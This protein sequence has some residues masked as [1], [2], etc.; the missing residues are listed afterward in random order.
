MIELLGSGQLNRRQAKIAYNSNYVP[1]M[2]YS[3]PAMCISETCMYRVTMKASARFLQLLGIEKNFPRAA[4]F[5]PSKFGGIGRIQLYT[6]SIYSKIECLLCNINDNNK[7]G[8]IMLRVINWTQML[9]GT[10]T[11]IL[12]STA[13]INWIKN[14]WFISIRDFLIKCNATIK[15][16]HTWIPQ[17]LRENDYVLMDRMLQLKLTNRELTTANNWRIYFQVSTVAQITNYTGEKILPQYFE[18]NQ[19]HHH[20]S[21]A[22][23]KWPIQQ[24]PALDTFRIWKKVITAVTRSSTTGGIHNLG[25]WSHDYARHIPVTTVL[26]R[27]NDKLAIWCPVLRQ[28]KLFNNMTIHYTFRKFIKID[29]DYEPTID[30]TQYTTV[31]TSEDN[32]YYK[33]SIRNVPELQHPPQPKQDFRIYNFQEFLLLNQV[34]DKSLIH[35]TTWYRN[36]NQGIH[37]NDIIQLCCDGGLR[38]D[39]AGYGVILSINNEIISKTIM[40]MHE[41]YSS[42]SSYRSEAFGLL[43]ALT[44]YNKLQEYNMKINGNRQPTTIT[45]YCDNE[46]LVDIVNYQSWNKFVKI[47]V[48]VLLTV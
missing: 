3:T 20:I 30:L 12:E 6:E 40:R 48:F 44:L 1:S 25:Q 38:N 27:T 24:R 46:S 21:A 10:G 35:N 37:P 26:H 34:W 14:N 47:R 36:V 22:T 19:L 39:I 2:A 41:E 15:I 45:I 29:F 17:L 4:V 7:L 43:G 13:P 32:N 18:R 9:C 33:I 16:N 42:F 28:W 8:Q 23:E 31:D 5:G 11:P